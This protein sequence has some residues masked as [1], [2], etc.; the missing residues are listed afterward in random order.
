M[1]CFAIALAIL[2]GMAVMTAAQEHTKDSVET[3][4]KA[5]AAKKA[6]LVDVREKQEWDQ[7][8]LRDAKLLPLS[9]LKEEKGV[10][11]LP[12][13]KA[14]YL[15]CASGRRC[16]TAAEILRAKGYDVRPLKEGYKDLLQK[17]LPKAE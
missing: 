7:G 8:H 2:T 12:K 16:L 11:D 14:I 13:D 10:P 6:V 3:L 15:H 1:R 9:R 5:L 17:G 4:Q